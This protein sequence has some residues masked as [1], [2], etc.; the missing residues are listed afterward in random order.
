MQISSTDG[1]LIRFF[2]PSMDVEHYQRTLFFLFYFGHH[3]CFIKKVHILPIL[4]TSY[5]IC[6]FIPLHVN[7]FSPIERIKRKGKEGKRSGGKESRYLWDSCIAILAKREKKER[8]LIRGKK[9]VRDELSGDRI[10]GTRRRT[11]V[12]RRADLKPMFFL[13]PDA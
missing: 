7:F 2:E 6:L 3:R 10:Q 1:D 11:E 5:V 13:L 8:V 9:I 4:P 12:E